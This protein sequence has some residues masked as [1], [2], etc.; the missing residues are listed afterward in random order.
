MDFIFVDDT[1]SIVIAKENETTND[2]KDRQQQG[3]LCRGKTLG[4]IG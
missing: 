3:T 2:V 4:I 1:D